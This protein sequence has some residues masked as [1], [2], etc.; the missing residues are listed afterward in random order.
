MYCTAIHSPQSEQMYRVK[1]GQREKLNIPAHVGLIS[2]VLLPKLFLDQS[3]KI[4]EESERSQYGDVNFIHVEA[5]AT[6]HMPHPRNDWK[7]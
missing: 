3:R 7:L 5:Q 6:C 4:P 1:T 2:K